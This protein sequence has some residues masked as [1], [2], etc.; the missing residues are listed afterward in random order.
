MITIHDTPDSFMP[1][2]N[3]VVWTFSSDQTAQANFVYAVLVFI[4]DTQVATELVFPENGIYGKFDASGYASNNCNT[5]TI[6]SDLLADADNYC[7]VR[8]TITERY[9]NPRSDGASTAG[10][11]IVCWKAKML[12]D[13]WIDWV[14]SDYVY[15][16]PGQWLTNYPETPKVRDTGEGIRLMMI[17]NETSITNFKV[18]L[19]DVD[20]VSI[21]SDTLNF[22]ATS[23]ML[24]ICNVSPEVIVASALGITQANFTAATYYE[25]S[26]N[27]GAGMPTYRIDLDR[28]MVYSTYKR[29][30]FL[31]QWGTIEAYSFALITRESGSIQSF[32]YRKTFGEWSG[33][34]F[35]WSKEQGRDIDYAKSIDRKAVCTSD[36]LSQAFQNWMVFNLYGSP[37]VYEEGTDLMIRRRVTN[38]TLDKKIQENDMLFLEEVSMD[39]PTHN[40][41]VI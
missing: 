22:T 6:G 30:H 32:G 14:P 29:L 17:N 19:F 10:T 4:N 13:D 5:P 28:E 35:V 31:T 12:D 9:G 7:K 25:I 33:A 37:L 11:N 15:N 26:A 23:F 39:L 36:W 20:G 1:S 38:R 18:E 21:V 34:N 40:S 8:I 16:T 2:D 41:M 3:P 24:L 27:S